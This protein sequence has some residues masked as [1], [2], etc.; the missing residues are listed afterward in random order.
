MI[1]LSAVSAWPLFV[2]CAISVVRALAPT[3]STAPFFDAVVAIVFLRERQT[4]QSLIAG[5][6]MASASAGLL[7]RDP[8][9]GD[10][11]VR[12]TRHQIVELNGYRMASLKNSSACGVLAA[13]DAANW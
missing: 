1:A 10:D 3:F 8:R 4:L 11:P 5:S 12:I 2:C 9:D 7:L 6:L 13:S